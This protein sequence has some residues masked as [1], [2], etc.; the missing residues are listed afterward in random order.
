MLQWNCR[1]IK[2]KRDDL[3]LLLR[4]HEPQVVAINESWL[5]EHQ[6]FNLPGYRIARKDRIGHGGG[7]LL[8]VRDHLEVG[9]ATITSIYEV[10]GCNVRMSDGT[11]LSVA[12][13]YL[14]SPPFIVRPSELN[15]CIRQMK[16]PRMLLGDFNSHGVDWGGIVNDSRSQALRSVFDDNN[17]ATLNTGEP[18][19]IAPR[20][21]AAVRSI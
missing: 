13:I 18:T 19:R 8:A 3:I 17:M 1:S 7:V 5:S 6:Q 11:E 15:N 9:Y 20:Q 4:E 21:T 10:V 16:E 12:S 2:D 14:P